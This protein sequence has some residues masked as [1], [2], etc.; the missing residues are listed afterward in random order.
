MRCPLLQFQ[1]SPDCIHPH[2]ASPHLH[3]RNFF[4]GVGIFPGALSLMCIQDLNN[5]DNNMI[6]L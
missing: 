2:S 6:C 3:I 1:V 5:K 4:S